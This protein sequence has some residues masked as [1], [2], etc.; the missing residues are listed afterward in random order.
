[1]TENDTLNSTMSTV[2]SGYRMDGERSR[3][4]LRF[5]QGELNVTAE[6]LFI[7]VTDGQ[8]EYSTVIDFIR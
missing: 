1:M 8:R 5:A 2:L 3:V 7:T 4:W 6:G